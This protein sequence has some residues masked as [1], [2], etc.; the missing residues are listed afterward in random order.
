MNAPLHKEIPA[1]LLNAAQAMSQ[2]SAQWDADI[3]QQISDYIAIPA[4]SPG[5][6][7][8]WK[9]HGY[10]DTVMRNAAA[11][12][13]AQKVEGLTLEVVR[14]E[15]RTPVLFFEVAA[16][17]VDSTQTVLM[18]GHLDKQPEFT[19]WRSDLGP[20]TP[21]YQDGKLYGRGGADDGY[22][23]YASIAAVQALKAQNVPHP[24]IVGL[25]E[26]CEESG[27][28]DLLPYVDALRKRLGDVALVVCLDSGAGNYDQLWLT[29]SLRGMGGGVLKVQVLD[30]GVHSGDASGV[31]PSSFRIMRHVLDRLEDSA[32]GRLLPQSFHCA[33]PADRLAQA[34]ATAA[35]LGDELYKRFPWAHY[36]CEGSSAF[37]LPMTTDP[38]EALLNRTWR[39]TL[40]VT[41]AEGF[42]VMKDAGNVLRPFTAFK[43]SLRFPP[44]V[45]ASVAVQELKKL[46]ED[47]APYNAVVTFEGGGGATGWNAPATSDWF[48][49]AL[50]DASRSF[51]GAPCGTIGQ[52]G[53]IPLMNMLSKGFPKAQ[54]MVCGVLGPKSNAHGPNEFL[55]VPYAKKLTAAVAHVMSRVPG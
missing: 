32:T 10:I 48:E 4:K 41:G 21:K 15:G 43:L 7:A 23:V 18:Y 51:F 2:V 12:V 44:L 47:N 14:L 40:S 27:S 42:P 9:A 50:N 45:D 5:F 37:T 46:L 28:Y 1:D 35:T 38:L 25:I 24:R 54:M 11:W 13:E 8:D 22:A 26:T 3:V 17:R 19:G 49:N 55:H 36:D 20:W 52:G 16:T 30:E 29:T 53:T 34:A 6:D 39:P 33:I 31:V